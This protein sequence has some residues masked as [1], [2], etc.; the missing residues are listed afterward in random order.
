MLC[1]A[2]TF[3]R[4]KLK[5]SLRV[6]ASQGVFMGTSSWKYPG[7]RGQIYDEARYVW[8]GKFSKKRFEQNCLTEYAEVFS[9]VCVDGAYYQFP[10]RRHLEDF[11]SAVPAG[12]RFMFKVTDEITIKT[13]PNLPRFGQRA[14]R[15]NQNFLNADLFASAFLAP[16]AVVQQKV[17]LLLFEFSRFYP[18]DFV[19]GRDFVEALDAFL[20]KLPAGWSWGVEIRNPAFLHPDYF[21]TLS[22]HGVAHV[23]NSWTEMPPLAQQVA[24]PGSFTSPDTFVARFQLKPGRKFQG[25]VD[26][27]SPYTEVRDPYPEARVA[28]AGLIQKALASQGKTK[29]FIYVNNR[30]EGNAPTT[31]A[32]MLEQA[33]AI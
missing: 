12:F 33:G 6:L 32:A 21:A 30:L 25:A 4:D 22:K 1:S 11:A 27:F 31:I 17:G 15:P 20:A 28:S 10:D 26:R 9:T 19:R 24:L 5:Q 14:G 8:R 13:F 18:A 3:D 23:F 16:C 2:V 29:A 7:W